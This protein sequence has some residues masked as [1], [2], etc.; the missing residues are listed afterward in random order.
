M[1]EKQA[2]KKK[3][4]SGSSAAPIFFVIILIV[5]GVAASN[6]VGPYKGW[7][8]KNDKNTN[9]STKK[10]P[11]NPIDNST[12]SDGNTDAEPDNTVVKKKDDLKLKYEEFVAE[13]LSS[14][15]KPETGKEYKIHSTSGE[16]EAFK[17][18]G[19]KP[20]KIVVSKKTAGGSTING[21]SLHYSTLKT[22]SKY[23]FFPE[24]AAQIVATKKLEKWLL[25]Q[26]KIK[27]ATPEPEIVAS[28][29][30]K[31]STGIKPKRTSYSSFKNYDP[32]EAKSSPRLA[33]A[34]L[35]LN[36]YLSAQERRNGKFT[37]KEKCHAKQQGSASVFYMYVNRNFSSAD[38]DFKYQVVDGIR[39]FW[40]MRCMSNG[41]A[42][43][44][45]A[46]LCIVHGNKVIGGSKVSDAEEI[47]IKK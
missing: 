44:S 17:L 30:P 39:R 35:E 46:Y 8:N 16:S 34:A 40:A 1:N 36:Q 10:N 5:G 31:T 7:I 14:H 20:H 6:F 28:N 15:K 33:H 42:R 47:W 27:E 18:T 41:V 45:N 12:D 22:K 38:K 37:Y 43:G 24:I 4:K 21:M 9:A 32:S 3:K 13:Y 26:N 23:L 11:D 19:Y 29:E 25:A 2:K